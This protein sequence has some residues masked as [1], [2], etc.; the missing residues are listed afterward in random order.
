MYTAFSTSVASFIATFFELTWKT[1][2]FDLK[3]FDYVFDITRFK[4][5]VCG[6][7]KVVISL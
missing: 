1:E 3:I 4:H 7:G 2:Y 6:E 5:A